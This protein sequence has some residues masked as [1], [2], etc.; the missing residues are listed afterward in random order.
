MW[1]EHFGIC[2]VEFL[3][4]GL[5]TVA[6]NSGGPKN[7]IIKDLNVGFLATTENEYANEIYKILQLSE[8]KCREI[9][10]NGRERS[11]AFSQV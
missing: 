2:I 7:D 9:A 10:K 1:N 3:A 11:L 6:H 5:I 4:A 8:Q